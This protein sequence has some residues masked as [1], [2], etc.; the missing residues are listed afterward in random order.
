MSI[1]DDPYVTS[2][3][4]RGQKPSNKV[5]YN[6]V[7][8]YVAPGQNYL[9]G[10][11]GGGIRQRPKDKYPGQR[12]NTY[13][14]ELKKYRLAEQTNSPQN[15]NADMMNL[16]NMDFQFGESMYN[17]N[18]WRKDAEGR[19]DKK[20][21]WSDI[22][23]T[24]GK[25]GPLGGLKGWLDIGKDIANIGIGYGQ[26]GNAREENKI[27]ASN[28]LFQKDAFNK[29]YRNASLAYNEN[30]NMRNDWKRAQQGGPGNYTMDTLIPV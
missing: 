12:L 7:P 28:L 1:W 25:G 13:E 2:S 27:A 3:G 5:Q 11:I 15:S 4:G 9:N 8:T 26:L 22:G 16:D 24:L 30:A 19:T 6:S 20:S 21:W 17:T 18:N 14:D 10:M 23:S 29:N